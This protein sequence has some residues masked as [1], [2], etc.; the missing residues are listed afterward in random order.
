[1]L[2]S[3]LSFSIPGTLTEVPKDTE[4]SLQEIRV[5]C[6]YFNCNPEEQNNVSSLLGEM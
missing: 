2:S 6:F 5:Q 3:F 4:V 1:M